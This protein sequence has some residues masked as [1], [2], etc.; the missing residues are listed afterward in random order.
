MYLTESGGPLSDD[1]LQRMYRDYAD[2]LARE[3]PDV[4]ACSF[5]DW[6]R[7]EITDGCVRQT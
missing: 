7:G 3:L 4:Q 5:N 1:E 6:L 2:E